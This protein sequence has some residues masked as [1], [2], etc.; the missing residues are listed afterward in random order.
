MP[1]DDTFVKLAPFI[2]LAIMAFMIIAEMV[3]DRRKEK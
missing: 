2:M 1:S 3:L